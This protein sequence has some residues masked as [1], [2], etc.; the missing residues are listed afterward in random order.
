[1]QEAQRMDRMAKLQAGTKVMFK[2]QFGSIEIGVVQEDGSI[3]VWYE[4]ASYCG[5]MY[6]FLKNIK[7]I[8]ENVK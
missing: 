6:Y 4:C 3:M 5:P 1:M 7:I 2:S 8:K